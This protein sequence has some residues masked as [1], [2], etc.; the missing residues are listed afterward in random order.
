MVDDKLWQA[1]VK[2]ATPVVCSIDLSPS[3]ARTRSSAMSTGQVQIRA[4]STNKWN[5]QINGMKTA[6]VPPTLMVEL[7]APITCYTAT[8]GWH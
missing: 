4:H 1:D 7:G 3:H 5:E 6:R 8:P 2:A